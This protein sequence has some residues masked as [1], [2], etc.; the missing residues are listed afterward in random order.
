M[1]YP[2]PMLTKQSLSFSNSSDINCLVSLLN[3]SIDI[4]IFITIIDIMIVIMLLTILIEK[5]NKNRGK[6]YTGKIGRTNR[7]SICR[8]I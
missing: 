4:D 3:T 7:P 2:A 5:E 8:A 6:G 1:T